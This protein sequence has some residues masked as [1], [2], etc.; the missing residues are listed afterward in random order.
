MTK[1]AAK[2]GVGPTQVIAIERYFPKDQRIIEDELS[3][4]LLPFSSKILVWLM[5]SN[6]IRNWLVRASEKNSP[7]IWGGMM[8]R[9]RYIDEKL[10]IAIN[11]ME[12]VVNLGGDLITGFIGYQPYQIY[13][14]GN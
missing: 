5:K 9:K 7:G 8:S 6:W 2:T 11:Q 14:F 4:N 3:Y 12:S 13:G 1:D 10:I